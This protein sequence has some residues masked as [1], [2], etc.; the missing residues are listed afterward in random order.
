MVNLSTKEDLA[1]EKIKK[2]SPKDKEK[3]LEVWYNRFD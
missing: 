3:F 2:L 1:T